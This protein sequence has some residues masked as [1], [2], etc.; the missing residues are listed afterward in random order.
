VW[1]AGKVGIRFS[2]SNY[3]NGI[4]YSDP[5]R[6]YDYLINELNTYPLAYIHLMEPLAPIAHL[7][8]YLTEV[9]ARYR[10][11]YKGTIISNG[12]YDFEKGEK[13]IREGIADI[14]AYGSLFLANPDLP[15]RFAAGAALNTPERSTFYGGDTKGYT[16]YPYMQLQEA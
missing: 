10:K 4:L 1:G 2:P 8:H 9:T 15:D 11:I 6:L 14:I 3:F 7:P 16:D 5:V 12:G 13:A